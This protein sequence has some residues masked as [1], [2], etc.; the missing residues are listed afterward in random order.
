MSGLHPVIAYALTVLSAH[1]LAGES[2]PAL[3]PKPPAESHPL[4]CTIRCAEPIIVLG[5]TPT[6]TVTITNRTKQD[7]VL[8][9]SL[10]GSDG[11][12]FPYCQFDVQNADGT[13]AMKPTKG[14]CGYKN[15]LRKQDFVTVPAEMDF[16]PFKKIDSY[17]FFGPSGLNTNTFDK[18]GTYRITFFYS[19]K[20][21]DILAWAGNDS[22]SDA[23]ILASDGKHPVTTDAALLAL[24]KQ[25]PKL[26]LTSN[27]L[28]ITVVASPVTQPSAIQK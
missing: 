17:G 10:D 18:L 26:E 6:I 13:S 8:V 19:T 25:V 1:V 23:N 14:L 11:R 27:T 3:P 5:K 9:G 7:V 21:D 12:R 22:R 4:T 2:A 28:T 15:M 16:D 20:N 24:F